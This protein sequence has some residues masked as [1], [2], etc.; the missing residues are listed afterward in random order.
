MVLI[1]L[2]I[3]V[4]LEYHYKI[5]ESDRRFLWFGEFSR[6]VDEKAKVYNWYNEWF[7]F[8]FKVALIPTVL[9]ILFVSGS[10]FLFWLVKISLSAY[11]LA[12][13]I[14]PEV[15]RKK[16]DHYFKSFERK[17]YEAAYLALG[18]RFDAEDPCRLVRDVSKD[19][20][21][22]IYTHYFAVMV[23][24]IVLGAPGALFYR[25][26]RE[27]VSQGNNQALEWTSH[28][29]EWV[30]SRI[31]AL[32]LAF[33]GNFHD[34]KPA[35]IDAW[36]HWHKDSL[37]VIEEVGIRSMVIIETPESSCAENRDAIDLAERSLLLLLVLVAAMTI[38]NIVA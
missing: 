3:V 6:W 24:F 30:P 4:Y 10:G 37:K 38:I 15:L 8:V 13:C 34:A 29:I 7:D 26:Y 5:R 21:V 35:L 19:I 9:C 18:G 2:L 32:M 1:C 16:Y 20:I 12:H 28:W 23:W 17:D 11:I 22:Q 14:G 36:R 31:S 25:L 33:A 27:R